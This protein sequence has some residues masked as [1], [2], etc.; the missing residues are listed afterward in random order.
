[1]E[2]RSKMPARKKSHIVETVTLD[3]V[4][5]TLNKHESDYRLI[6]LSAYQ[7]GIGFGA[8][9]N[10]VMAFKLKDTRESKMRAE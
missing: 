10:C 5:A 8:Y 3:M 6:G 7:V 9:V 1:M 2:T 4:E